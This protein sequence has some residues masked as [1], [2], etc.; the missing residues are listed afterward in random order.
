MPKTLVVL[1]PAAYTTV[2][3]SLIVAQGFQLWI[4][5]EQLSAGDQWGIAKKGSAC[6]N[7]EFV[8]KGTLDYQ[9]VNLP[10]ATRAIVEAGKAPAT[11]SYTL[12]YKYRTANWFNLDKDILVEPETLVWDTDDTSEDGASLAVGLVIFLVIFGLLLCVGGTVLWYYL[13]SKHNEKLEDLRQQKAAATREEIQNRATMGS[14][15]AAHK[16]PGI[17]MDTGDDMDMYNSPT[18]SNRNLLAPNQQQKRISLMLSG[19]DVNMILEGRSPMKSPSMKSPMSQHGPTMAQPL[20][21]PGSFTNGAPPGM[22]TR[23]SSNGNTQYYYDPTTGNYWAYIQ[24]QDGQAVPAE[25]QPPLSPG[26]MQQQ[27]PTFLSVMPEQGQNAPQPN[28]LSPQYSMGSMTPSAAN[29][30]AMASMR[31]AMTAGSFAPAPRKGNWVK[32]TDTEMTQLESMR[33][34]KRM[35]EMNPAM[36]GTMYMTQNGQQSM[37]PMSLNSSAIFPP[38]MAQAAMGQDPNMVQ[39]LGPPESVDSHTP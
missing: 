27:Q 8:L 3:S 17:D 12:C 22:E 10:M 14:L 32:P 26:S 2:P 34:Q 29:P 19:D 5:G 1:G 21:G 28:P 7:Q 13:W 37:A 20:G 31:S 23:K 38:G 9:E 25:G 33:Q 4:Y 18:T 11:G 35:L 24:N 15:A 30:L 39:A 16:L 6:S 36:N